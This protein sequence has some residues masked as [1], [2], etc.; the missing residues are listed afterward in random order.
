M[1]FS[2]SVH[3]PTSTI[4]MNYTLLFY[5]VIIHKMKPSTVNS[6]GELLYMVQPLKTHGY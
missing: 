1:Q 3:S 5:D 4:K 6:T 2:N